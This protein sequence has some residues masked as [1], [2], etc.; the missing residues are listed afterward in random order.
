MAM[1][2][3]PSCGVVYHTDQRFS[4]SCGEDSD[5]GKDQ[6]AF[7]V[8]VDWETMDL[9]VHRGRT[10]RPVIFRDRDRDPRA[11]KDREVPTCL[12]GGDGI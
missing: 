8:E 2:L 6:Q 7:R 5:A 10:G 11:A 3:V 4:R 1:Y 12:N 9:R